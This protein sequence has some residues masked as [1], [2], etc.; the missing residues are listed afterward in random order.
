MAAAPPDDVSALLT[1][2]ELDRSQY[3]VFERRPGTQK[4]SGASHRLSVHPARTHARGNPAP[5]DSAAHVAEIAPPRWNLLNSLISVD[6]REQAAAP[7]ALLV[8]ML[9]FSADSGGVGKTTILTTLAS[10]L[11][12]M[13]ESVFLA[14][15]DSQCSLPMHFGGQQVVPGRVRTLIPPHRDFGELHLYACSQ[16]ESGTSQNVDWLPREVNPLVAEVGRVLCEITN[17]EMPQQQ[18]RDLA[19]INLRVLVP[20]ISSV[21]AVTR[22]LAALDDDPDAPRSFYLL[23]K[24]DSAVPFHKDLRD[25]LSAVLGERLLSFAIRRTDQLPEALAAGLT[26][27][28]YAPNAP[29]VGDFKLLAEWLRNSMHR[30][31]TQPARRLI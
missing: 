16:E 2:V 30:N 3:K 4:E 11:S 14:Y 13:G 10:I 20:D 7:E 29:V 21:L 28:D 17:S 15:S 31:E 9:T 8:P 6:H 25:R 24:Y 5:A 19:T 22:D 26:V 23:N 1:R 12:S 27:V 18:T